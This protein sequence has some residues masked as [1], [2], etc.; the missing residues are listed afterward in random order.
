MAT[1]P[2]R[3]T[4]VTGLDPTSHVLTHR[5]D[6]AVAR[7]MEMPFSTVEFMLDTALDVV[8]ADWPIVHARLHHR[9][10]SGAQ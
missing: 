8:P 7:F 4:V 1:P 5:Y 10:M 3:L 9:A 2:T 6:E